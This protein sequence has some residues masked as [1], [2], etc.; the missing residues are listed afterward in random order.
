MWPVPYGFYIRFLTKKTTYTIQTNF[1]YRSLT[2]NFLS[3]YNN[4]FLPHEI[5]LCELFRVDCLYGYKETVTFY[6]LKFYWLK[7]QHST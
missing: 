3:F 6:Y 5:K 4:S 1:K 7:S 2:F